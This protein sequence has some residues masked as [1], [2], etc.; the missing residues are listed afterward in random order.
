MHWPKLIVGA[1]TRSHGAGGYVMGVKIVLWWFRCSWLDMN[2]VEVISIHRRTLLWL[3]Y[4]GYCAVSW[5]WAVRSGLARCSAQTW[6]S[7]LACVGQET[8]SSFL[9]PGHVW[10][11]I[12]CCG[13]SCR[14]SFPRCWLWRSSWWC[15]TMWRKIAEKMIKIIDI[16]LNGL[17]CVWCSV[18]VCVWRCLILISL[19]CCI[20]CGGLRHWPNFCNAG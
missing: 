6:R 13:S 3:C 11:C 2:R 10:R 14:G 1:D 12:S 16:L 5:T 20:G 8:L 15:C 7:V 19:T 17:L 18:R 4:C 9:C